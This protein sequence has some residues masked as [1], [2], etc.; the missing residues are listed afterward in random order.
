MKVKI[1]KDI[2]P[3]VTITFETAFELDILKSLFNFGSTE[4][5]AETIENWMDADF[6]E[7][8]YNVIESTCNTLAYHLEELVKKTK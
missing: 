3:P 1:S 5:G 6:T 7:K 4:N 2:I 8:E